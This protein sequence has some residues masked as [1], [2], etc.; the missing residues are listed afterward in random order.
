MFSALNQGS[1]VYI[2]DK[3]DRPK[4]KLGEIVSMSQP[5]SSFNYGSMPQAT[6]IDM[7]V[8]VDGT[9]YEYNSIPSNFS[10]VTYNN[11]KLTISETKQG[12]QQEVEALLQNSKQILENLGYYK[13]NIVDCETILKELNPQFAKDK[14][15][16]ERLNSLEVKFNGVEEK[17]DQLLNIVKQK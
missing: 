10:I 13:Q 2:L 5:K 12:L 17:I 7:K 3:T 1:L 14:E 16:D 15:R 6:T 11:G 9:T 4:L 8:K